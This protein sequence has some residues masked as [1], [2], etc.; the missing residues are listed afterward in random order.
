MA[1]IINGHT[2]VLQAAAGSPGVFKVWCANASGSEAFVGWLK[3]SP[4]SGWLY[5][6]AD[7]TWMGPSPSKSDATAKLFK[8]WR[9]RQD[10]GV[11][12]H[13]SAADCPKCGA[14]VFLHQ[15]DGVTAAL[16]ERDKVDVVTEAGE[17][18]AAR[19]FHQCPKKDGPG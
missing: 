14:K 16:V 1:V 11:R 6:L 17:R 7:G 19:V 5:H 3:E 18:C 4:P 2:V 13:L 10:A 12:A 9:D 8:V 15:R